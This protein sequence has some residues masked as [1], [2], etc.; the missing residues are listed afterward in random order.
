MAGNIKGITIKLDGDA[1]GLQKAITQLNRPINALDR[2]LK[3]I[4]RG[5]KFNP[6]NAELV[7]QKMQVLK[8]RRPLSARS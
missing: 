1:T 4:E 6:G 7:S 3:Q 5:L 8:K 2:E